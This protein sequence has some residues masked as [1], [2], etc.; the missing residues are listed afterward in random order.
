MGRNNAEIGMAMMWVRRQPNPIK[1]RFRGVVS[2][3]PYLWTRAAHTGF[4]TPMWARLFDQL[5]G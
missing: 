3:Y 5:A 1:L 2:I 4:S